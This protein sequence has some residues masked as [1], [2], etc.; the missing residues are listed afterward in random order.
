VLAGNE[1]ERLARAE[2]YVTEAVADLAEQSSATMPQFYLHENNLA[3]PYGLIYFGR[4]VG[5]NTVETVLGPAGFEADVF[6]TAMTWGPIRGFFAD[7][8]TWRAEWS[9][10]ADSDPTMWEAAW[11]IRPCRC[12]RRR[13]RR[14]LGGLR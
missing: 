13:D 4:P 2:L 6:V 1:L 8:A 10:L 12:R 11:L 9:R 14:P 3:A 7:A 5:V